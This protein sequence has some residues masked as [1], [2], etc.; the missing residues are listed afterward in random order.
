VGLA[1]SGW[2][3]AYGKRGEQWRVPRTGRGGSRSV[4][5][6]LSEGRRG[7][8]KGTIKDQF[9]AGGGKKRRFPRSPKKTR[10]VVERKKEKSTRRMPNEGEERGGT[11]LYPRKKKRK[12]AGGRAWTGR[13]RRRYVPCRMS[14][15]RV[16]TSPRASK[17]K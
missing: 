4:L 5:R 14:K 7:E 13:G 9:E 17:E 3:D 2:V 6:V 8:E 15:G 10:L 11:F 16:G 1:Q 12:N